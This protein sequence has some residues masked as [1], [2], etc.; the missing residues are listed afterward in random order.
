M[1]VNAQPKK[2]ET[3]YTYDT[4]YTKEGSVNFINP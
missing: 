1:S 2:S 3:E 4:G